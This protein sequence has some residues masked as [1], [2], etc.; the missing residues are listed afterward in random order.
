M[1]PAII[2][3]SILPEDDLLLASVIRNALMEFGAAKPG[4]VYFDDTTDH[5]A[6]VFKKEGSAYFVVILE[7]DVAGGAGIYPTENLPDG[8]CE[9]VKLYLA[10]VAR[11][12]GIGKLLL[13]QCEEAAIQLGYKNIYLETMPELKVAVPMYEKMGYKYLKQSMGNSGHT[14]C[15]IWMLKEV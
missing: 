10:K 2:I 15:D 12:K 7:G 14:G 3:R 5:L 9:L 4:T 8:T 11:G 1:K 6:D 13:Q